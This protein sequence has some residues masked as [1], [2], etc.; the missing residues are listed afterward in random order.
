M[1][2]NSFK[3]KYKGATYMSLDRLQRYLQPALQPHFA[4]ARATVAALAVTAKTAAKCS[5]PSPR[6]HPWGNDR[7]LSP[8]FISSSP[9]AILAASS[10][11]SSPPL[12]LL[13]LCGDG[14]AGWHTPSSLPPRI[15]TRRGPAK[16]RTSA[17]V[18]DMA[19]ASQRPRLRRESAATGLDPAAREEEAAREEAAPAAPCLDPG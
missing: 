18:L 10:R 8:F 6:A 11:T 19:R 13:L 2:L 4:D 9:T 14:L 5:E 12:F 1:P 7:F 17:V 15:C 16:R 3:F